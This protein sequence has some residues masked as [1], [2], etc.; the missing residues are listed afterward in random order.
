MRE[1]GA[2]FDF[3]ARTDIVIHRNRDDWRRMVFGEHDSKTVVQLKLRPRYLG[4]LRVGGRKRRKRHDRDQTNCAEES[5]H[6]VVD[7]STRRSFCFQTLRQKEGR[8]APTPPFLVEA[9]RVG[10]LHAL[11][12]FLASG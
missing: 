1:P 2:A 7:K 12:F 4:G 3:I 9:L 6:Q 11:S 8:A 10:A 5:L